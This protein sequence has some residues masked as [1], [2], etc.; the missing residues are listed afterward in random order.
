MDCNLDFTNNFERGRKTMK[1]NFGQ[2]VRFILGAVALCF[3]LS[4]LSFA[5]DETSATITGRITDSTGAVIANATILVTNTDT[6]QQKT[7]QSNDEGEYTVFPLNPGTYT[8]SV[9]Q[10][11]FKKSVINTSLNAKDRR[12]VDIVLEV[13][14]PSETVLVT[15]EAPLLQDSPTGQALVSGNQVTELPL[16]N[17]N[18]IRLLEIVPGVSSDL[19]DESSFGLTSTASVSINGLRRNAVN[20][21][22]DG[23][24]NTDVGSNITLLSAPTV[25]SIQ[26]VK[27]LTS[28][29]T[30]EVGRSGGGTVIITTRGGGNKFHGSIY[31]FNRNSKFSANSFFNN[32][33]GR[34]ADGSLVAPVPK[35]RYNNFGGTI[36]GPVYFLN[37]GE[38]VPLIY[39]GKNKTFFFFSEEQRRITRGISDS[40]ALVPTVLERQ[41]N[42]SATLGLPICR[43]TSGAFSTN[44]TAAGATPVTAVDTAGNTIA[45]RQSQIFRPSDNRPYAGN[46]IPLGDLDP[47]SLGM[48]AAYPLPNVGTNGFTYSPV[49]IN[50]TQQ[51]VIRIDHNFNSNHKI[52]GRYT[53][54]TSNTE[55]TGGLFNG[56]NLPNVSTTR[57]N[58]PGRVFA[59]SYTGVFSSSIVNEVTYNYSTNTI[60]SRLIGRGRKSD[61]ANAAQI[62]EFFPENVNGII[63]SLSSRFTLIGSTQGYSIEYGNST[64]RDIL[65]WNRGNHTFKFGAEIAREFK[66]E[67]LGGGSSGGSYAF[68]TIQT[69]GLVGTSAITGTGDSF[70][71]LLLGRAN[72]Y[73]ESQFDPRIHFRFGRNEFFVQDTWRVRSNLTLDLGVRYQYFMPP[74]DR[75]NLLV[76]FN[77]E[78]YRLPN[79]VLAPATGT[80]TTTICTTATCNALNTAVLDPLNGIG[81]AAVNSPFGRKIYPSDKNNF[82][83]RVGLAYQPNF[84][85]GIGRFLF[86]GPSKSVIRLGYGL[87][88]DQPLVGITE[89]T[90]FF[91]PPVNTSVSFTSTPT[92]VITF[93]NPGAPFGP[94]GTSP[95][96]ATYPTRS[97]ANGAIAPDFQTPV[98]Q[99]WSVGIQREIFKNAVVDISY[100]GTKGDHLIRRRNINFV[101]PAT[102]TATGNSVA[103][104]NAYR[105]YIGFST[106]TQLETSAKSR[107]HG[108]LSSFNYRLAKGFTITLAY[109]F[110][111]TLTDS[112]NDRDAVDDPQNP[113]DVS[114]EYAEARTSRPH[115]FSASYVYELPFF[116]KSE[117][118]LSRLFL[119]GWQVSGITAIESGAPVARV[120]IADT[121]SGARGLYPNA[122]SDPNGGLAGTIDP[123][124]GLPFIFDPTS[125]APP[126]NGTYG[127]LGRAFARLPGRNQTNLALMK[128][129]YFDKERT[130]YLQLRAESFNLFNHTQFTGI[131]TTLPTAGGLSNT[132]FGRPSSTR[133]PREFQFGAKLYF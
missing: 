19:A 47:R 108:L 51:E 77:P 93:D 68:S 122:I 6:K 66:N 48:L 81:R 40:S 80:S 37:F 28:N 76:G 54:D 60:D 112:T 87:Y 121:L 8:V 3:C 109:T 20:Y 102:L 70:G 15:D 129:F 114:Q 128:Q 95:I 111:K 59:V 13:G 82:S 30:A 113:F 91:S 39:N 132:V 92:A 119:A 65:T 110:S 85:T 133:L 89:N 17:R 25:D 56:I 104:A 67:N 43:Q 97:L 79:A 71:S 32:R 23:V 41:G 21:L 52:F 69:Q 100:V 64:F 45:V 74:T 26:E 124:T 29:Y 33:A 94:P 120:T 105:P 18:F 125:L 11:G 103:N 118:V 115:I 46:I 98:A 127:N 116:R 31:D 42:F 2:L 62:G 16:N 1:N 88:Y 96:G 99:V 72:T 14:A 75:D 83:P 50:N 27:V 7:A 131:G 49:N 86:G 90:T 35:L 10:T 61:Y 5:Q 123:V 12:P 126:A 38:D 9:E 73:S 117:N 4:G 24:N 53:R 107:Y 58:V 55:E 44:C 101:S 34:R 106:I 22:V 130:M 78:L 36:S 63:P 57:T 84:E